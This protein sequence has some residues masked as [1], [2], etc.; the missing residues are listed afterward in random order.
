MRRQQ[1]DGSV[2]IWG[3]IV[4]DELVGPFRVP[5]GSL[6]HFVTLSRIANF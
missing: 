2:M 1:Q 4:G 5:A 6:V 3:G